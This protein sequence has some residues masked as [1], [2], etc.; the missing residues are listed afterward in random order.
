MNGKSNHGSRAPGSAPESGGEQIANFKFNQEVAGGKRHPL[1]RVNQAKQSMTGRQFS[2][3]QRTHANL[4]TG[5]SDKKP[6]PTQEAEPST[7]GHSNLTRN[8]NHA[9]I[10]VTHSPVLV[11]PSIDASASPTWFAADAKCD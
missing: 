2:F 4:D 7:C 8:V 11:M 3:I 6:R 1:P 10:I 9:K 5:S